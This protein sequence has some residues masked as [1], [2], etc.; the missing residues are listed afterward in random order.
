M[1]RLAISKQTPPTQPPIHQPTNIPQAASQHPAMATPFAAKST[2]T[3]ERMAAERAKA[4]FP[5]REMTYFL[6]GGK[7][8]TEIKVRVW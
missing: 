6:D 4:S 7:E 8:M 2:K 5:V 1:R 3:V